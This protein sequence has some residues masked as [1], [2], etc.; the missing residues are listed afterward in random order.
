V[1]LPRA[2][3][4]GVL[5]LA[6]TNLDPRGVLAAGRYQVAEAVTQAEPGAAEL[7][8]K[9]QAF[10]LAEQISAA[11]LLSAAQGLSELAAPLTQ[12]IRQQGLVP[13]GAL[14][15]S[16]WAGL[17][18]SWAESVRRLG[19]QT[20]QSREGQGPLPELLWRTVAASWPCLETLRNARAWNRALQLEWQLEQLLLASAAAPLPDSPKTLS[21]EYLRALDKAASAIVSLNMDLGR[22]DRAQLVITTSRSALNRAS[23][24]LGADY[25][26]IELGLAATRHYLLQGEFTRATGAL[27]APTELLNPY[28]RLSLERL[29][30]VARIYELMADRD[31]GSNG[32]WRQRFEALRRETQTY[33][34]G[35][36]Q[37][38]L[39]AQ[40]DPDL[41]RQIA[42]SASLLTPLLIRLEL[43]A[44]E[45][46]AAFASYAEA[47]SSGYL[48]AAIGSMSLSELGLRAALLRG[49]AD[50]DAERDELE[51]CMDARIEALF[52]GVK[53]TPVGTLGMLGNSIRREALCQALVL[54]LDQEQ[55]S[56]RAL[57]LLCRLQVH[58]SHELAAGLLPPE[59]TTVQAC[60]DRLDAGLL[61]YFPGEFVSLV[62]AIDRRGPRWFELAGGASHA[63]DLQALARELAGT[64]RPEGDN[65]CAER[66]SS[67]LLP[68]EL[69]EWTAAWPHT[70]I[71]GRDLLVNLDFEVL[72]YAEKLPLGLIRSS[73]YLPSIPFLVEFEARQSR[74]AANASPTSL[75]L[76]ATGMTGP[77]VKVALPA[78]RDLFTA[79]SGPKRWEQ[80]LFEGE[81]ASLKQ[82]H[83]TLGPRTQLLTLFAHGVVNYLEMYPTGILMAATQGAG[84]LPAGPAGSVASYAD[85]RGLTTP[86]LVVLLTCHGAL[87]HPRAGDGGLDHPAG[88]LL[89]SGAECVLAP[90]RRLDARL[91]VELYQRWIAELKPNR[92]PSEALLHARRAL[93]Q[94]IQDNPSTELRSI[95]LGEILTGLQCFGL[96]RPVGC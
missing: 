10:A 15:D 82:L 94:F 83:A 3:V 61:A 5:L 68:Q 51:T 40:Q 20:L 93:W 22:P 26:P 60:L 9:L 29:P 72:P 57:E 73:S 71:V 43:G 63:A 46:T 54:A 84:A 17:L 58:G 85:L 6:I 16:T 70:Y 45:R 21:G 4:H 88:A 19:A 32:V 27:P 53:G 18:E 78:S 14:R 30:L 34:K 66:L 69:R 59:A 65:R 23:Q 87:G 36:R 8:A 38:E 80:Q 95:S 47:Q 2:L 76:A 28:E 7:L 96:S 52:G 24:A 91:G 79:L 75:V 49:T 12:A 42:A 1:S 67:W 86:P 55:G 89:L 37:T 90:Q 56:L 39:A 50:L 41:R 31:V 64:S 44:G 48:Q 35:L 11:E 13:G 77:G 74:A 33:L 25:S 81:Q 92:R 62:C